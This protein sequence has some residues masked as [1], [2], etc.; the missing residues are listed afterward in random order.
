M[1]ILQVGPAYYPAISIGGPIFS[2]YA[3]NRMLCKRHRVTVLTTTLGLSPK[4]KENIEF[5]K[6]ISSPCGSTLIYQPYSGY[7]HFTWSPASLW[8]LWHNARSFDVVMIQGVWNFPLMAAAWVCQQQS[9][10]YMVFPRGTLYKET[11]M[12]RSGFKKRM[13]LILFVRRMLERANRILFTTQDEAVKVQSYLRFNLRAA[14]I[15]NIVDN[16]DFFRLPFRGSLRHRLGIE[17]NTTVL[18]HLGRVS[19][20]K[21]LYT[22]V[23]MLAHLRAAGKPVVLVVVGGDDSGH[24]SEIAHLADALG[25]SSEVH[26]TGLL[27]REES[28]QA[29]VDADIFI[30]P[31]LS[32]N[33]GM[34]VVEA[35]LARLPVVISDHVGIA[36]EVAAAG[37]GIVVP[38]EA[39][40]EAFAKAVSDLID[41]SSLRSAL[42]AVAETF[43]R[44]FYSE[45]A[46]SLG[47]EHLFSEIISRDVN[48][49]S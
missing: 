47:L 25:L 31:S 46:V 38:L 24:L 26:F 39:G 43:A 42:G 5:D 1:K 41:D 17:A 23:Q 37:A 12:L 28:M 16:G 13:M 19:P 8:W 27:G 21:G 20:K 49:K 29:L 15:P 9:I 33:F 4:E 22:T 48:E 2:V 44:A 10:P 34:A 14:V 7:D 32:E 30:L 40:P 35:M 11:V 18:L 6:P 36:S 45:D 3:L